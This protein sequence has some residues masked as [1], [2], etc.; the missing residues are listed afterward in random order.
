[1]SSQTRIEILVIQKNRY[2]QFERYDLKCIR[3]IQKDIVRHVIKRI[4][5]VTNDKSNVVINF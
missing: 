4:S 1:M 5:E 2:V 3:F